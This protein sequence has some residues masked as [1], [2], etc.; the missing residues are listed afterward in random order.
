MSSVK[1]P[2]FAAI[3]NALLVGLAEG[4]SYFS[5]YHLAAVVLLDPYILKSFLSVVSRCGF[6]MYFFLLVLSGI[7]ALVAYW[8]LASM[9]GTRKN[10]K[11]APLPGKDIDEY[12]E[13]KDV[14][15]FRLYKGKDKIHIQVFHDA[16]FDGKAEFKGDVLDILEQRHSWAKFTF[17]PELFK[18]VF[19]KLI[20]DV[21]S[22][23]R[24]QDQDQVQD[25][26]DRGDEF[27]GWYISPH[28]DLLTS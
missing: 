6:K 1:V 4:N 22:H 26:Y 17:T 28:L 10:L 23:S 11:V 3:K 19:T 5:N 14:E 12:I 13:I 20:P 24:E 25:H 8:A 21:I 27:Y 9:Y 15:L 2:S 7:P 18:H 16:Y